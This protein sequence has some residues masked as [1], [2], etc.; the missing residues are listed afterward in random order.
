MNKLMV[1]LVF[2]LFSVAFA[3]PTL[4]FL[5]DDNGSPSNMYLVPSELCNSMT[6][7]FT[8]VTVTDNGDTG[9]YSSDPTWWAEQDVVIWYAMGSD[10]FGRLLTEPE[11]DA[12]NDFIAGGGHL[13]VTG[14]DIIGDPDDIITA[15]LIRSI[16]IGDGPSGTSATITNE[17]SFIASGPYGTFAGS[18]S[19][20]G[21]S[22]HDHFIPNAAEGCSEVMSIDESSYSKVM[23]CDVG[24][25]TVTSWGGNSNQLDWWDVDELKNMCRNWISFMVTGASLDRVTWGQIKSNY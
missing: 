25:G 19:L 2:G 24:Q 14:P 18:I 5:A 21:N 1:L 6:E 11:F 23:F 17:S 20:A 9:A 16:A 10:G 8:Y 22:D 7:T 4:C 13:M 12:A 15:N 3:Q